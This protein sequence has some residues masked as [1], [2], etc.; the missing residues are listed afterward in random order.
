MSLR[1]A[2]GGSM[3][4][5]VVAALVFAALAGQSAFSLDPNAIRIGSGVRPATISA[6]GGSTVPSQ[7]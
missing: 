3:A 7:R 4:K 6:P 2:L 5:S 1:V